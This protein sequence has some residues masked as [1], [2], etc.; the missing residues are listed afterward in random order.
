MKVSLKFFRR[1]AVGLAVGIVLGLLISVWVARIFFPKP[2]E[3]TIARANRQ[4]ELA[5]DFNQESA[6]E[7]LMAKGNFDAAR[8]EQ[9]RLANWKKNFPWQPTTDP[10]VQFDP[11]RHHPLVGQPRSWG[12]KGRIVNS[13]IAENNVALKRFFQNE[14]RFTKQFEQVYR[15][16]EGYPEEMR[17]NPAQIGFA[18]ESLWEYQRAMR[19]DPDEAALVPNMFVTK[20]KDPDT[21][22]LITEGPFQHKERP[23]E[24]L[25]TVFGRPLTWS[26]VAD[27][28]HEYIAGYLQSHD[29]SSLPY[30]EKMAVTREIRDRLI[31]EVEGMADIPQPGFWELSPE[32]EALGGSYSNL[33][34]EGHPEATKEVL[35][36]YVGWAE[37]L[38]RYEDGFYAQLDKS[39]MEGDPSLKALRPE[40]FP[41]AGIENNVLVDKDGDPIKPY[42][43]M[44]VVFMTPDGERIPLTTNENGNVTLPTPSEIEEMRELARLAAEGQAPPDGGQGV[45][46][47]E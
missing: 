41:P 12:R 39:I 26:E 45:K 31:A 38:Q 40:F 23:W 19:H 28:H 13:R 4:L 32:E 7:R 5:K 1:I 36:P 43:G 27:N 10:A 24:P 47:T 17:R 3:E 35:V 37:D 16:L 15:I 2:S 8:E 22:E 34:E 18:F 14:A 29:V 46:P 44:N 6:Y 42:E 11:E 25:D 33:L 9:E 21:G 30:K 20:W